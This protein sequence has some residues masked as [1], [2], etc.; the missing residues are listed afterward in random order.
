LEVLKLEKQIAE[1]QVN[2]ML[3]Y[4]LFSVGSLI[5]VAPHLQG[6][7]KSKMAATTTELLIIG[8]EDDSCIVHEEHV[9]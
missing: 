9:V 7:L 3:F 1:K 8:H 4:P 6:T 5:L 2:R